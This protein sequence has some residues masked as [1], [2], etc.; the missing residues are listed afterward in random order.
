MRI[1]SRIIDRFA[2]PYSLFL[3]IKNPDIAGKVK[4]KAGL[5]LAAIYLYTLNPIAI[6]ANFIPGLGWLEDIIIV[7]AAMA[8][9]NKFLPEINLPELRQKARTRV[10]RIIFWILVIFAALILIS[11]S[12]LGWL[13]YLAIRHWA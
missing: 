7:S 8:L 12:L 2:F 1:L 11:L 9:T 10:K 13:I 6:I 3:V 5:V 4:L